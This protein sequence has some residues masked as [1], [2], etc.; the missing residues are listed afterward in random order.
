MVVVH[1]FMCSAILSKMLARLDKVQLPKIIG[2]L[3]GRNFVLFSLMLAY[4]IPRCSVSPEH[5]TVQ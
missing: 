4:F 2:V 5:F 3:Q 1:I